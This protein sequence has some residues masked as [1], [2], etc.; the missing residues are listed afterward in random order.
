MSKIIEIIQGDSLQIS[1][2]VGELQNSSAISEIV[3]CSKRLGI[4][5]IATWNETLGSYYFAL[6]PEETKLLPSCRADYSLTVKF[7]DGNIKT[8]TLKG[9]I[10]VR[11]KENCCG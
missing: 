10:F 11:E 8:P 1:V 3:F 2:K 9:D 5:K 7:V 6:S 4:H